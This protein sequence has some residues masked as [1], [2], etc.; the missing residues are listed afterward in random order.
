VVDGDFG[1]KTDICVKKFQNDYH[2]VVDG[3]VGFKTWTVLQQ[4]FPDY[5]QEVQNKFLSESDIQK[6]AD[7]LDVDIATV[8]AVN[9]VESN[10]SG[11]SGEKPKILFEGHV[12]WKQLKKHGI[13]PNNHL[14][15]NANVL[16]SSWVKRYYNQNQHTRLEKAK[17]IHEISALESASW[18]LF[19][20]MGCHWESLGYTSVQEF[21]EKMYRSEGDQLEAFVRYIKVNN[22][23]HY[24]KDRDW[25]GFAKRYNGPS[26][27]ENRYDTKMAQAYNRFKNS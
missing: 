6:A 10:G 3:L 23:A 1:N 4:K 12:F 22:L 27:K 26:Y 18:G 13:N 14:T 19:Q 9:S 16:Y 21:V 20:I 5:F 7:L 8:K 2:L 17:R 11:F 25:A 24:L 15:G